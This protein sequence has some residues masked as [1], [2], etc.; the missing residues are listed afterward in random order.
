MV[1]SYSPL[2]PHRAPVLVARRKARMFSGWRSLEHAPI[3]RAGYESPFRV[4]F[5]GMG[6]VR[7]DG[8][9]FSGIASAVAFWEA[10]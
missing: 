4:T 2:A 7:V 6:R 1:G 10:R 5:S 9:I 3:F 8:R